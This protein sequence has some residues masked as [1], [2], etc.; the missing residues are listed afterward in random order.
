MT[1]E[2]YVKEE[3]EEAREEGR[4]EGQQEIIR[5]MLQKNVSVEEISRLTGICENQI[6]EL[7]KEE[8]NSI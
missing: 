5:N 7:E 6:L 8:E 3:R 4:Q 2:Q 1:F